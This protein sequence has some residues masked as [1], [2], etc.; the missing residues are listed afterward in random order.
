MELFRGWGITGGF[1]ICRHGEGSFH[2]L[3]GDDWGQAVEASRMV[4]PQVSLRCLN[5]IA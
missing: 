1:K 5:M 4:I 3:R 2:S